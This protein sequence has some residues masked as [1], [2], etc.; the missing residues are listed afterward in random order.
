MENDRQPLS[1]MREGEHGE[2]ESVHSPTTAPSSLV[3]VACRVL[4]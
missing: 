1:G 3:C 2:Q 4:Q